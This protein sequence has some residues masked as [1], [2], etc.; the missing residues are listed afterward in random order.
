MGSPSIPP[1]PGSP[2]P[3]APP[4][5]RRSAVRESGAGG[6]EGWPLGGRLATFCSAGGRAG[7]AGPLGAACGSGAGAVALGD[8][9]GD[10]GAGSF[11]FGT[12]GNGS[13]AFGAGGVGAGAGARGVLATCR[14]CGGAG[15]VFGASAAWAVAPAP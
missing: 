12:G 1:R 15:T 2:V 8:G 3:P 4:A 7:A 13:A 11:A 14:S 6:A 10:A 9:S 5:P